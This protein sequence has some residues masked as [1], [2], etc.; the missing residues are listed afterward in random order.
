MKAER[1]DDPRAATHAPAAHAD[2]ILGRL[3]K[4]QVPEQKLPTKRVAF[5]P[6]RRAEHTAVRF[7]ARGHEALQVMTRD[8]LVKDRSAREVNIVAAH[9]HHLLFV[10]HRVRRKRNQ[11]RFA[12]E[13][14]RTPQ[15]PPV[16][17]YFLSAVLP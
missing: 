7:V 3:R 15:S 5:G 17:N 11:N 4:L 13:K 16:R 12:T 14:E 9:A 6:E 1:R 8:K 10:R 2:A